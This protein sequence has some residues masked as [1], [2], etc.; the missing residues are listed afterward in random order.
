MFYLCKQNYKKSLA[1]AFLSFLSNFGYAN[2]FDKNNYSPLPEDEA[3]KVSFFPQK[4]ALEISWEIAEEHYL[5]IN[6]IQI[7]DKHKSKIEFKIAQGD[8]IVVDDLF[9]ERTSVAR[10]FLGI[11]IPTERISNDNAII[12]D[13]QGCK[14]DTYC[15][16]V[17]SKRFP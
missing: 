4:G 12:I 3:F 14:K 10:N 2:I 6:S 13:Y 8:V 5:Y 15:Y 16:P 9:F 11:T 1:I 7:L 17:I